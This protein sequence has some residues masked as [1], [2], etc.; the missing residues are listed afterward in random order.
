MKIRDY[1]ELLA[2]GPN[3]NAEGL[4]YHDCP[5][6][7]TKGKFMVGCTD[8]GGLFYRCFRATCGVSGRTDMGSA[9]RVFTRAPKARTVHAVPFLLPVTAQ[10]WDALREYVPA[11][12]TMHQESVWR[13]MGIE[14]PD[15]DC[16][17]VGWRLRGPHGEY[18]G[19]QIRR[20]GEFTG[21]KCTTLAHTAAGPLQA[22]FDP[23][24]PRTSALLIVEDPASALAASWWY[25]VRT[26]ALLG[27]HMTEE[28]ALEIR[29][30]RPTGI[31][32]ALDADATDKAIHMKQK[33][34]AILGG[35]VRVL[36]LHEDLKD[37]PSHLLREKLSGI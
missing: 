25:G 20:Y 10:S 15:T 18:R 34:G 16:L 8:D 23:H 37:L 1:V 21:P 24:T 4:S 3:F 9:Q 14:D 11:F 27:T 29:A 12:A 35:T 30:Q 28:M 26:V 2:A 6:C 22:W 36:P 17:S 5:E 33:W 32:I 13:Y 31:H 7:G 19:T